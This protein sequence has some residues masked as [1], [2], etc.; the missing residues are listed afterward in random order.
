MSGLGDERSQRLLALLAA[1]SAE[2]ALAIVNLSASRHSQAMADEI[3][4]DLWSAAEHGDP[5]VSDALIA[6]IERIPETRVS[7]STRRAF[8]AA[9]A[10]ESLATAAA[11]L[12]I[13]DA[14]GEPDYR[15]VNQQIFAAYDLPDAEFQFISPAHPVPPGPFQ[16]RETANQEH[17]VEVAASDRPIPAIALELRTASQA[18]RE[19]LTEELRPLVQRYR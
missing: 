4:D 9:E 11:T 7:D 12:A 8:L 13:G 15:S 10:L 3:I 14:N 6:R 16:Q 17:D 18:T 19:A 1:A 5:T 2:R